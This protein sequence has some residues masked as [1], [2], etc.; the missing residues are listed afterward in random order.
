[1]KRITIINGANLNLLGTREPGIYGNEDFDTYLIKLRQSYPEIQ[2][3]YFQNN[4][5]GEIINLLQ[6]NGFNSDGIIL[7]AGGYTHTS[8]AIADAVAA[9]QSPVVEVH[10]SNIMA[11]EEQRHNSL[12]TKYCKGLIAGL[13]LKGYELALLYFMENKK[14]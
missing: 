10:I 12:L 3:D 8:V 4:V 7:N 11:R 14:S 2:I 5:E 13:G 9:I 1:M 6:A